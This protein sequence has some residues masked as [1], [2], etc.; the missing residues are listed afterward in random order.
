MVPCGRAGHR[1]CTVSIHT[2]RMWS[3]LLSSFVSIKSFYRSLWWPR[4]LT[5]TFQIM[6][7]CDARWGDAMDDGA[8]RCTMGRCGYVTESAHRPSPHRASYRLIAS[9]HSASHR[10]IVHRIASSSIASLFE[11]SMWAFSAI[12]DPLDFGFFI[13]IFIYLFI[14]FLLSLLFLWIFF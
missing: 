13:T 14:N 4:R 7:R 10:C 8:M 9:P 2:L 12:I 1:H 6:R 11:T 3:I 5:L